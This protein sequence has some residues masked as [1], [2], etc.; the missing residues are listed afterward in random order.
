MTDNTQ[1]TT[2]SEKLHDADKATLELAKSKLQLAQVNAEKCLA[3]AEVARLTHQNVVLQLA[4]KYNLTEGDVITELG[5]IK[6]KG[7]V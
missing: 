2:P 5:E 6:R 3:E 7:S 4:M 1:E